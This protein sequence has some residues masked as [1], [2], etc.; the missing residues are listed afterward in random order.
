NTDFLTNTEI[1][2][3]A[4][5]N[6]D[7][8]QRITDLINAAQNYSNF[9]SVLNTNITVTYHIFHHTALQW[10]RYNFESL[11]WAKPIKETHCRLFRQTP[12]YLAIAFLQL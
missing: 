10:A 8:D 3:G 5:T 12:L 2:V 11:S 9:P 4:K 1:D 7:I 6:D